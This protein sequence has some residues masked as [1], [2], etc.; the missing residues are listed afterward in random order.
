[1]PRYPGA[2]ATNP[3]IQ[4]NNGPLHTATGAYIDSGGLNGAIPSGLLADANLIHHIAVD[5]SLPG[6]TTITVYTSSGQ[7]LYSYTVTGRADAPE[8]IPTGGVVNTGNYPF[9]LG[10]IYVS[11]SPSGVGTTVFDY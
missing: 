9:T 3:E 1:L 5:H 7:E 4:I 8:V 10:P 2:P 11:D 6:G